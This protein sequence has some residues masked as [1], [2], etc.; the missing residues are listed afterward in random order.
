[1]RTD[2]ALDGRGDKSDETIKR[3]AQSTTLPTPVG[4]AFLQM[5]ICASLFDFTLAA[6]NRRKISIATLGP[7]GTSSEDAARTFLRNVGMDDSRCLLFDTYEE[8]ARSVERAENDLLLVANAYS[9]I[10]QFYISHTLRLTTFFVHN[11]PPYGLAL[12]RD[13][14]GA[15]DDG[16]LTIATH[17][18]PAHFLSWFIATSGLKA[19][20]DVRLVSS[21][22]E[23]AR[24]AA[25]G[26]VDACITNDQ[27]RVRYDLE[28]C[29]RTRSIQMLWSVFKNEKDLAFP[30]FRSAESAPQ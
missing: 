29:S 4:N 22:S 17:P 15:V 23:A 10:N 2:I 25:R 24:L 1:V 3:M 30:A 20:P 11:T 27:A 13:R 21:T 26:E 19:K 6:S 8:A 7:E 12:R 14:A 28:F 18:A 16:T 5:Q 9:N